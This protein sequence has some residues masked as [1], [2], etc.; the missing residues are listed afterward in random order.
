MEVKKMTR[1]QAE[2][3]L[4]IAVGKVTD[5]L[6]SEIADKAEIRYDLSRVQELLNCAITSI[7][8]Y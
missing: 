3:K 1:S 7:E 4:Y 6:E 2:N 8:N 5:V